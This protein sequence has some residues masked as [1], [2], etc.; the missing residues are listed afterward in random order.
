VNGGQMVWAVFWVMFF[1][2]W[3]VASFAGKRKK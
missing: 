1:G 2:S 3:A